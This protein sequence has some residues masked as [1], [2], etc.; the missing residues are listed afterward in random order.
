M[1]IVK[2]K[3]FKFNP[4]FVFLETII[5]DGIKFISSII[6]HTTNEPG[7]TITSHQSPMSMIT[8]NP[9]QFSA[10]TIKRLSLQSPLTPIVELLQLADQ[11][12]C[13]KKRFKCHSTR[14]TSR[15]RHSMKFKV[16][17]VA[18]LWVSLVAAMTFEERKSELIRVLQADVPHHSSYSYHRRHHHRH[19]HSSGSYS[20]SQESRE[21][22]KRLRAFGYGNPRTYNDY[23]GA[24]QPILRVPY[25]YSYYTTRPPGFP[26]FG[27][28]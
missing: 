18:I 6:F 28:K 16:I 13:S 19:R 2:I 11:F 7:K 25:G 1:K 22:K 9:L 5:S 26:L 15:E 8:E 23:P 12:A 24:Y 10:T 21:V 3:K 4:N 14:R 17:L 20:A 27:R